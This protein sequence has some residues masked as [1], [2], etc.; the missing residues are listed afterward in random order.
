MDIWRALGVSVP[1]PDEPM[2]SSDDVSLVA[3]LSAVDLFTDAES[4][5]ILHVIGSAL[6]RVADA[7]IAFYVQTVESDWPTVAPTP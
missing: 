5:E 2:F 4:D 7:T 3:T 1:G 6:S